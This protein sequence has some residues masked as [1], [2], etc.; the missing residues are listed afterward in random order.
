MGISQLINRFRG[1]PLA[2]AGWE[3]EP[4]PRLPSLP[5]TENLDAV[6]TKLYPVIVQ[7]EE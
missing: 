3:L 1:T 6:H 2:I 5:L 4:L 7:H